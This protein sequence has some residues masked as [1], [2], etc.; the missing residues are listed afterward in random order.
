[1]SRAQAIRDLLAIWNDPTWT[2]KVKTRERAKENRNL[3]AEGPYPFEPNIDYRAGYRSLH[4]SVV[5]IINTDD[6]DRT[7]RKRLND[8]L[9][10]A[11]QVVVL[12]E[13][14]HR[15]NCGCEG[16]VL[17]RHHALVEQCKPTLCMCCG[18]ALETT[19]EN[20]PP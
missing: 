10:E 20:A 11:G 2:D 5:D 3:A 1:M 6:P 19:G 12:G 13:E 9:N 18:A 15:Q 16:D 17:C 7:V 4:A 14:D 8:A